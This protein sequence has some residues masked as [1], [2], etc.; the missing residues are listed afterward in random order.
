MVWFGTGKYTNIFIKLKKKS[1]FFDYSKFQNFP[2]CTF[3]TKYIW[4]KVSSE[5]T[6]EIDL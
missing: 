5:Y 6:E 3:F 4:M 2:H 1:V